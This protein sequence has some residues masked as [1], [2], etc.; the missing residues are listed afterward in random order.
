MQAAAEGRWGA[1]GRWGEAATAREGG[2][3]GGEDGER[4]RRRI[5]RGWEGAG[6]W[7]WLR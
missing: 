5:G 6:G 4:R 3:D 2:R 7:R 1:G